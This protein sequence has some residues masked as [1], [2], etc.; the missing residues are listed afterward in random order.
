M[1]S[2]AVIGAGRIGGEVAFLA[3]AKGLIDDIVIC[4]AV[5]SLE[6]AQVLD[7]AHASFDVGIETDTLLM[8]DADVCVF[9]AGRPRSPETK[10]RADLLNSNLPV[11]D[12]CCN[13]LPAFGGIM[14][15][16]TNPMD[17]NN[18]YLHRCLDIEPSRCIGFGGQLD[19]ARFALRLEREGIA[20]QATILGEHGEH[21]VPVFSRLDKPVPGPKREEILTDLRGSSMEVIKG[22]GGTVFGPA[23]HIVR[24]IEAALGKRQDEVI[25]CSC[26]VDGEYG[27]SGL[28]IGLPARIG[29]DGIR[30]IVEWDL[31]AWEQEKL[32]EAASF[33]EELCRGLNV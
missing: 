8:R 30:E 2:L 12:E 19:S 5:R 13:H 27:L 31:D 16:V 33:I 11:L 32:D 20:G 17:V 1:T 9:A 25:P 29:R 21:Q 3:A 23:A 7:L 26:I 22:K 24:L 14:I 28:S 6:H 18:Y 10:T 15:T 4:D